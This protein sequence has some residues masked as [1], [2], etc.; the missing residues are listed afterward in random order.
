MVEVFVSDSCLR[1]S[2][3]EEHFRHLPDFFRLARKFQRGKG[4]LQVR[5]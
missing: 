4:T 5:V 2:L 3:M 1:Q